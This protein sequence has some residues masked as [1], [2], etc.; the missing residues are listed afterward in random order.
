MY[1]QNL[2][3]KLL[4]SYLNKLY[5]KNIL[6]ILLIFLFLIFLIDFIE[7]YRRASD[8]INLSNS[9]NNFIYDIIYMSY[10]KSPS[11]IQDI[12]PISVL[13][14]SIFTF[15]RWRHHNY[16]IIIRTIGISLW[17]LSFPISISVFIIGMISI[18]FLNPLSSVTN[19]KFK[20]LETKYFEHKKEEDFSLTKDGIW[21]NKKL[22]DGYLIIKALNVNTNKDALK[23]VHIF[24]LNID[25]SFNS[26]IISEEAI[27]SNNKLSLKDGVIFYN[28]VSPKKFKEYSI[29]T[30][31]NLSKINILSKKPEH[32]N[33]VSLY[34]Y[35]IMMKQIGLNYKNHLI[36]FLKQ[37]LQPFLMV[38]MIL[39]CA[40]LILKSNERKFPLT[41]IC[42]ALLIGFII[43]FTVDFILVLGSM[44]KLNPYLAGVGP[45][46]MSIL[47]GCFL[48]SSFDEI[49]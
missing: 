37:I 28:D 6:I 25:D 38:S 32:M 2:Y 41:L 5:L 4:F 14:S 22:S 16:F 23:K 26:K 49:K 30:D 43:Y 24:K 44:D 10:L 12:L 45:V 7:L 1:N 19:Q 3:P 21:I 34:H 42:L 18:I 40:P 15:Y 35:I 46:A 29:K 20:S 33:I 8:K 36:Y 13:I 31:F 17:R 47:I 11:T 48:V 9:D 39:I 27:F